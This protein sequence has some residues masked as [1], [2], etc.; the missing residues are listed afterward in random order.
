MNTNKIHINIM[1]NK[2]I[3]LGLL[4]LGSL[5]ALAFTFPTICIS[6][7]GPPPTE[8]QQTVSLAP[9][10]AQQ[11]NTNV[12][13]QIQ[14]ALILDTSGSMSGL[15]DQ[16][17]TQLW[18][19][20]NEL[21]KAH[22]DSTQANIS[23]ALY[24]YGNDGLSL[25]N[26]YIR[27]VL[28]FTNDLDDISEK[29]F[30]LNTNGGS[31]YCGRVIKTSLKELNWQDGDAMKLI[32]IA[33]NEP[34][35][36]GSVS[37]KTACELASQKQVSVYPIFC[38][39]EQEGINSGWTECA[40]LTA[41]TYMNIDSDIRTIAVAT[42]YDDEISNLN[43]QLNNTYIHYGQQGRSFKNKQLRQDANQEGFSKANG[44]SRAISKSSKLYGN[45]HWDLL[46]AY[47][48]DSTVLLSIDK[49]TLPDSLQAL[50]QKEIET[51]VLQKAKERTE[52]QNK[53]AENAVKR[54]AYIAQNQDTTSTQTLGD[55]MIKTIQKEAEKNG[56]VF[57]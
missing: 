9:V 50:E 44:V 32:Y 8:Y 15:I 38:G 1:K 5:T 26:G 6:K 20:I 53:I 27:Q 34:F 42:P 25:Y 51:L 28:P 35:N 57:N 2:T 49:E 39:N 54:T 52:I 13:N 56:F 46:D 22:K 14:I 12:S 24:E 17:K 11:D 47:K 31:E 43:I 41:G 37:P 29:L 40:Q 4:A 45:S 21:S 48:S 16:A 7:Q 36:Q 33:G 3:I 30:A 19:I 23:I 55:R 18:N 10:V